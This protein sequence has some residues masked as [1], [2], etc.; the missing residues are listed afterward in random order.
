MKHYPLK[1]D[2]SKAKIFVR[3]FYNLIE[4]LLTIYF[5][6]INIKILGQNNSSYFNSLLQSAL[7]QVIQKN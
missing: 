1:N 4:H 5:L 3:K 2:Y 7:Q 6:M